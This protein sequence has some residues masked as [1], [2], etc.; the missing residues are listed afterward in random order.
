MAKRAEPVG[1]GAARGERGESGAPRTRGQHAGLRPESIVRTAIA[2]ADDEGLASVSMRRIAAELKVEAMALY[3]HF[4]NKGALL[5]AVVEELSASAPPLDFAGSPWHEGLRKYA[6]AQLTTLS[7]HPNLV[8][9]VMT[10][11][12]VT[13][14]NLALLETLVDFL[15]AAGFSARRG[16]DMIYIVHELV[17]MHA[18]LGSE[19]RQA[20]HLDGI[21]GTDF[22]RLAEAAAAAARRS[23]TARF[24]FALDALI[25]GFAEVDERED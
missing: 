6:R 8:D 11:P 10:R 9:L 18:A 2:I 17:L 13:I 15:C 24:E 23:P 19:L 21:S 1:K 5:D 12:A 25:A 3:H 16:L 22:P 4:P 14:G 20:A 7:A